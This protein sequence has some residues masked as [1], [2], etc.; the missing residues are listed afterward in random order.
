MANNKSMSNA[1]GNGATVYDPE[2][3]TLTITRIFD[4]PK[5]LLFKVWTEP[6]HIARWWGPYGFTNTI[7]KM[8]VKPGGD[9]EFVMHGPDGR[10][11]KNHS[12]YMEIVSN[13]KIVFSHISPKFRAT[14]N[15]TSIGNKTELTWE[16]C[17]E[18]AGEL[19]QVIKVFKADDGLL[20]NVEKLELYLAN[21]PADDEFV[22]TRVFNSPRELVYQVWT[23]AKHLA[24]WW[25]PAGMKMNVA[26]LDFRPGGLFHYSM[27]TPEGQKMWGKFVYKEITAPERIVF[28]NSFSDEEGNT[29]RAPFS[30]TWPLEVLNI[31]T[32]N[33][34]GGMTRIR[35]RGKPVNATLDE[36]TTFKEMRNSMNQ[37]FGGTFDQLDKY[38][39]GFTK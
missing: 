18:S 34:E 26:S 35:L 21:V 37:G 32:L 22:I 6:E 23:D 31:L 2:K 39:S 20:Q 24:K 9:W 14:V 16:M 25:G 3:N 27:I 17:F 38:L 15:F 12:I 28:T 1:R 33:D 10:N 29:T 36:L 13:K 7:N 8:D 11:Y 4:A 30:P 5:E 19:E